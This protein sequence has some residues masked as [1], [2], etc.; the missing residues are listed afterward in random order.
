MKYKKTLSTLVF[1]II[2]LSIFAAALGIFSEQGPGSYEYESIRGETIKIYGK[3]LYQDMSAEL[4]VQGIGQDYVTLFV[5]IPI[6]LIAFFLARRGSL[7]GRYLLAGVLGYFFITYLFYLVMA[8]YNQLFLVYVF[9]M[10]TSFFA[11]ALTLFSFELSDLSARFNENTPLK[12]TGGFLLFT[13]FSIAFLWLGVVVPPLINGS[14]YPV[15]VEHYTTLIVQGMDLGLLLPL[16]V[17]SAV[18]LIRKRAMGYLLGPVYL[19][20]LS[21]LMAALTAKVIAMGVNGYSIIPV[22]FIMPTF[23]ILAVISSAILLK[24]IK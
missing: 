8:M 12:F 9:L 21:M 15:E 24:N 19:I 18:L 1:C 5:G 23:M 17:V 14:I 11:L 4:A 22:I 13:A 7:Q 16:A 2:I 20:F 3:G 10:G 6:L